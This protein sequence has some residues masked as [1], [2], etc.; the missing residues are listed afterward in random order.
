VRERIGLGHGERDA[1]NH[2]QTRDGR[3]IAIA[4]TN[5]R[6]FGG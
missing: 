4:C 6:M 1:A 5:D 2:Y 3:W